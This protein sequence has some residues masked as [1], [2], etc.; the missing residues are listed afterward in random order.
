MPEPQSDAHPPQAIIFDLDGT[1]VDTVETRI[2]AWLAVFAETG[3]PASRDQVAPLIGSDGRRLAREVAAVAGV[4][5]E[6]DRDEEIDRRSGEIYQGINLDPIPLP[7]VRDLLLE[8]DRRGISWA[9][10]TSSR[11]AQVTASV[12]ALE[13]ARPP[14]VVDGS[15]VAHAKPAPDLLLLAA[16][17]LGVAPTGAWYVGDS[18][19]DMIAAVAAGMHPVAVTAGAAV[20]PDALRAA[21]AAWVVDRI[22]QLLGQLPTPS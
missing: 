20:S 15:H 6:P 19:W 5:L 16:S 18:T 21:G 2:Q 1:L 11:A 12:T 4:E 7:G 9:I 13:L 17:E 10:A 3:I 22:D 8:L 14:R